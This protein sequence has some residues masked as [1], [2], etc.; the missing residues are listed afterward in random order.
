MTVYDYKPM[1]GGVHCDPAEDGGQVT[2]IDLYGDPGRTGPVLDSAGP[3]VRVREGVYRFTLAQDAP[4]GRYWCTVT[5]TPEDGAA[6][7][8][9]RT[10]RLDLPLGTG[11]VA[12][13]EQLADEL[14]VPLPLTPVQ[15]EAFR[16]KLSKAQADVAGYL[17]RPLVPT[18]KTLRGVT[19][20]P[21]EPLEKARAW[22]VP[23]VD[24]IV[25]VV[26]YTQDPDGTYT[27]RLR[28][29][30]DA[31]AEDPIVSY[32]L[33]H[34]AER[35]RN[36]P[37]AEA[38]ASGGRRVTS[39]SAEGQS[40]SYETAPAAGQAGALPTLD[41]LGDY[42]KRLWRTLPTAT[43]APWPYGGRRLYRRW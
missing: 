17:K 11:L 38:T 43:A 14:G 8:K 20:M 27:V 31:A 6:P 28:I 35:I 12:S 19:P 18:P 15:R 33:V 2:R 39:V 37:G 25:T 29:G 40:I 21:F 3:A 36:S 30:L 32:I 26:S 24:D 16:D 4:D 41:S 22:P 23:D 7:V 13:P 10:V 9:D 34:A 1:F 42:R 5:F